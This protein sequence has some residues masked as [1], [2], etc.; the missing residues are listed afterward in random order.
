MWE[1]PSRVKLR[2]ARKDAVDVPQFGVLCGTHRSP[3]RFHRNTL[4]EYG[5]RLTGHS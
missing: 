2:P 4:T 1:Q 3:T 5:Q